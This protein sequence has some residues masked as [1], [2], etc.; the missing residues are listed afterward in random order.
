MYLFVN[1][2]NWIVINLLN[3]LTFFVIPYDP[4][5][6]NGQVWANSVDPNQTTTT[7]RDQ[8]HSIF[9]FWTHYVYSLVKS[10]HS[11]FKIITVIFQVSGFL[12]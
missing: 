5:Y 7:A 10:H 11:N 1:Q 4:T 12:Q 6:S 8:G 2:D 9:I 3:I